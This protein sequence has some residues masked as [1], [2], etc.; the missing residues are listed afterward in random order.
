VQAD[1]AIIGMMSAQER[2]VSFPRFEDS[3]EL[4][5]LRIMDGDQRL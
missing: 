4:I 1:G 3:M 5:L 2:I